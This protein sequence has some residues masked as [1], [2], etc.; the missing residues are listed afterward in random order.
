M[1]YSIVKRRP[2]P[3]KEK[4]TIKFPDS[5]YIRFEQWT[6]SDIPKERD[7]DVVNK[8]S[9]EVLAGITYY[10]PWRQ[11]VVEFDNGIIFNGDCLKTLIEALKL[12]NKES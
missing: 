2:E 8:K 4:S 5:K 7:Y 3:G 10:A 12:L 11:F 9:G 1:E 6:L